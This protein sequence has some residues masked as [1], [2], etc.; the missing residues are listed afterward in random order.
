M[1]IPNRHRLYR[2]RK[3]VSF[4][5][6]AVLKQ[7]A[8]MDFSNDTEIADAKNELNN[9]QQLLQGH[10]EHEEEQI[11]RLLKLKQSSIYEVAETEHQQHDVFFNDMATKFKAVEKANM[12]T[13]KNFLGHEIY[14]ELREFYADNLKH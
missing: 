2:E 8:C 1:L 9:L 5:F 7:V 6:S 3:Y 10:A 13:E 4:V 11:H 12:L 14:L